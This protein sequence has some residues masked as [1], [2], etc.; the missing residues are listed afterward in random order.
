V[1]GDFSRYRFDPREH[2]DGVSQ[3]NGAAMRNREAVLHQQGRVITDDDLSEGQLI[4]LAWRAQA[5]RDLIGSGVC[6][7]PSNEPDGFRINAATVSGGQVLVSVKPGRAWV[8]G[9]LAR[10]PGLASNALAPL[11]RSAS[12]FGAPFTQP[13]PA[14]DTIGAGVRDAVVLEAWHDVLHGFQY[15]QQLI[16]PALGGP[17]TSERAYLSFQFRLLRLA[18]DED[19]G[20]VLAKLQ[21]DASSK[22]RLSVSLAPVIAIGGDCPV[23]GEGGYRGLEHNLYRIEI[24]DAADGAPLRF[25]WSPCNGG[26]VG[27]GRFDSMSGVPKIVIDAGRT[28]ILDSGLTELYLEIVQFDVAS[29][30]WRVS[31]G[32][33]AT[34]NADQDL[35]LASPPSF[36]TAPATTAP[37]FFRLWSGLREVAEF[38]NSSNP[39]ELRDGIRLVFD[40]G[41]SGALRPGDF[42]TFPV[43]AGE[44]GNAAVLVDAAPPQGRVYYRVALAEIQWQGGG[45]QPL[46]ALISDCRKRFRPLVQQKTCC[47]FLVGDG[48]SSF[49]DFNSLE[50]AAA[51]LPSIGGELCLL[52]GLHRTSLRLEGR[53]GI[54]I[55]GCRHRTLIFPRADSAAQPLLH[56][57]DCTDVEVSDLDMLTYNDVAV[58]LE[59]TSIGLCHDVSLHDNRVVARRNAIRA[60]NAV[61]LAI[62]D[63]RL[64]VLDTIDGRAVVSLAAD[65]VKVERN[66]LV[67]LPLVD[68]ASSEPDQPDGKPD[69]DP[70]DPCA[71]PSSHY[72]FPKILNT[73]AQAA[74]GVE[75]TA[76]VSASYRA[77]GG[78]HVRPGCEQVRILHNTIVGGAGHGV[79]LGGDLELSEATAPSDIPPVRVNVVDDGTFLALMLAA[80]GSPIADVDVFLESQSVFTDRS[81]ADGLVSIKAKPGAYTLSVTPSFR[82]VRVAEARDEGVL[83]TAVTLVP[84]AVE[85]QSRGFVHELQIEGN[86]ISKMGLSGIG[87]GLR[88]GASLAPPPLTLPENDPKAAFLAYIDALIQM[89]ALTPLLRATDPVRDLVIRD[90]R[91]HHN[92][93]APFAPLL[94]EAA[95]VVGFGGICLP[96]VES[97]V[98]NGN[99]IYEN[100]VSAVNPACGIFLGCVNDAEVTD[101]VLA[102]NGAITEDYEQNVQAGIRGGIYVRFAGALTTQFSASSGNK[103]AIRIHDNRIDQ[104]AGRALTVFAFGPVSVANN[105]L[106]SEHTGRFSF[107]DAAVGGV[108]IVNLG[109]VHRIIARRVASFI[110]DSGRFASVA[111][112]AL[113]GGETLFDAN[114]L[115][116]GIPNRSMMANLLLAFDDLGF[117]ANTSSVYRIDP[118]FANVVLLADTLRAT[119]SRMRED[120]LCTASLVT[121]ALRANITSLNQADHLIFALPST[122]ESAPIDIVI[123]NQV[124]RPKDCKLETA[125]HQT[126]G[127]FFNNSIAAHAGVLGGVL[128]ADAFDDEELGSLSAQYSAES[129]NAINATQVAS[130]QAHVSEAARMAAKHGAEHPVVKALHAQADAGAQVSRVLGTSGE[131]VRIKPPQP[132][133]GGAVLSG[134]FVNSRGQGLR[135]YAVGLLRTNGTPLLTVG[136]TNDVGFFSA[137]FPDEQAA[138]LAR[139][140]DLFIRVTELGGKEVL[141]TKQPVRIQPNANIQL[142]L[143]VPVRVVPKSVAIDGTVI[144]GPSAP[145][146]NTPPSP[147]KPPPST[148]SP[149]TPPSP[150]KPPPSTS[151]PLTPSSPDKA[152]PSTSSPPTPSSP[153]TPPSPA[154]PP[155]SEVASRPKRPKR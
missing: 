100:G 70:A 57:V 153:N 147:G 43:R 46:T 96:V 47:T 95:Q 54:R 59:G 101:N 35:E 150:D 71:T 122:E 73:Y 34:L 9:L 127:T 137:S 7:V 6:A 131:A 123:P 109:G 56:F 93:Q 88:F 146:P 91:L 18:A 119:G 98:I 92:L 60:V 81:D 84:R 37:V 112:R 85:A 50:E 151:S 68:A 134:R 89:L 136:T 74:W 129:I 94:L 15:P 107:L 69:Q 16:E 132:K 22:G 45:E 14:V 99:H 11:V 67:V 40:A 10:L 113:P 23:V 83:V 13:Q 124:L 25:K 62:T 36:G 104:S 32:S 12:Y 20:A 29:G 154:Q 48:I 78:I 149:L 75:P 116:V 138:A 86:D 111:E 118:L 76:I 21:D 82:I 130:N 64:H 77:L 87:F 135:N 115:R 49:G 26:L 126:V 80:N 33:T 53:R 133:A 140:G 63:N 27:R 51:Q 24:A 141:R 117:N 145:P 125:E 5:G 148:S 52:P 61:G 19:C 120:A 28:A 90:N 8:D 143:T 3:P 79:T 105:H 102:A 128:T 65:S 31:Y 44:I 97:V 38:A 114:F 39:V 103:P 139:E 42:W 1:Y 4:D 30:V 142:T 58:I 106:N 66:T 72:Q 17:D 2:A 108:L 41:A 144:Y 152:P 110:D 121:R 55:H 155:R